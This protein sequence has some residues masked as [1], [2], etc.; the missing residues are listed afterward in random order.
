M[1]FQL[2]AILAVAS[3]TGAVANPTWTA[4]EQWAKGSLGKLAP[5]HI[6]SR[7]PIN[8]RPHHPSKPPPSP[9]PRNRVCYVKSHND[10]ATDDSK[11][12][13]DALHDCNNGGHVV[14]KEGLK[15]TIGTAL[16]LTFLN[17]IDIGK[18]NK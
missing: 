12:I 6:S 5:E 7:P 13:L 3:A 1:R 15:Y 18:S 14:F 16:D 4:L 9:P 10:G 11:Y 8:C 2:T 17:H